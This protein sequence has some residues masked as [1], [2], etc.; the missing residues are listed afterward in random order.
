MRFVG[1]GL[2]FQAKKEKKTP[3][4]EGEEMITEKREQNSSFFYAARGMSRF[5]KM[6]MK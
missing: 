5:T 3:C 1:R 2:N 6:K 4:H